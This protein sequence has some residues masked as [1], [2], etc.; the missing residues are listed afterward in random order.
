MKNEKYD[1][2]DEGKKYKGICF[3]SLCI[4]LQFTDSE[5]DRGD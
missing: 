2:S 4:I 5:K 3:P 1:E